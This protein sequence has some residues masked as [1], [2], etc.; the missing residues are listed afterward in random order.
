[1]KGQRP[2]RARSIVHFSPKA[3]RP[4]PPLRPADVFA[5]MS[6]PPSG[7]NARPVAS[8]IALIR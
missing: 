4:L 3:K 8:N 6:D 7:E 1:M 5:E 2:R